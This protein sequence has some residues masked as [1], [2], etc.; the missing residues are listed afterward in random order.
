MKKLLSLALLAAILA[1][2]LASCAP[3]TPTP[4]AFTL[5]GTPL[6]AYEPLIYSGSADGEAHTHTP[7]QVIALH[8]N[9]IPMTVTEKNDLH[10]EK[11]NAATRFHG[12]YLTNGKKTAYTEKDMEA[13][14]VGCYILAAEATFEA[15][16]PKNS[17]AN[18][19]FAGIDIRTNAE[20]PTYLQKPTDTDLEFWLTDDLTTADLTAF[21]E[22]TSWENGPKVFFGTGYT[23]KDAESVAYTLTAYPDLADGGKFVT[24]VFISDPKVRLV[25]GLTAASAMEEWDDVL[26]R[27]GLVKMKSP[28]YLDK[29]TL[30]KESWESPDGKFHYTVAKR[31]NGGVDVQIQATVTN[32]TGLI[33]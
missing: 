13:L 1:F 15:N 4:P 26:T 21:A 3:S 14:P 29:S 28:E 16:D 8:R 27:M 31:Y 33:Y 9:D 24:T 12:I 10:L 20:I 6:P 23:E 2:S 17:R 5:D 32:R 22:Q 11:G 25:E 18:Y 30:A 7:E 19:I